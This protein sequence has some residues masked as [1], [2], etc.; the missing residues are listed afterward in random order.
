[1]RCTQLRGLSPEARA[2]L[3]KECARVPVETCPMCGHTK[4]GGMVEEEYEDASHLG[5]FGDGPNLY[6][7]TLKSGKKVR[8][9]AQEVPWSSGPCIFLCLEDEDGEWFCEWPEEEIENA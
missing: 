2:F 9:V 8:E 4:G 6:E 3:E 7:Y 1:M 5:M